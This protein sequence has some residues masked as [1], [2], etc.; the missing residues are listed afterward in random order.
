MMAALPQVR[1]LVDENESLH[2]RLKRQAELLE[3]R[4]AMAAAVA[5]SVIDADQGRLQVC[6]TA[7]WH[8]GQYAAG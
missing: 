3:G 5:G 8:Q 6:S 7:M 2:T 1:A 4:A